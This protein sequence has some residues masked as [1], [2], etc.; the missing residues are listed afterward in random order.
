VPVEA[1]LI[2]NLLY[3]IGGRDSNTAENKKCCPTDLSVGRDLCINIHL[4]SF[5]SALFVFTLSALFVFKL[6]DE[7]F[8]SVGAWVG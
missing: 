3:S 5:A 1:Y 4:S 2:K 6:S 7:F 8:I